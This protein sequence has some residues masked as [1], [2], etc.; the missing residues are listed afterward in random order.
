MLGI[1]SVSDR[2]GDFIHRFFKQLRTWRCPMAERAKK[3]SARN[4]LIFQLIQNP[5]R[6]FHRS[7]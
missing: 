6:F 1:E 2:V 3:I 5:R 7:A 4:Q